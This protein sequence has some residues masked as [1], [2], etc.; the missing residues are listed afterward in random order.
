MLRNKGCSSITPYLWKGIVIIT[1]L[2]IFVVLSYTYQEYPLIQPLPKSIIYHNNKSI[3]IDEKDYP[4]ESHLLRLFPD[5]MEPVL[6][7]VNSDYVMNP[8]LHTTYNATDRDNHP[9]T[10]W[11]DTD[12]NPSSEKKSRYACEKQPL[13]FPLLHHL[14]ASVFRVEDTGPAFRYLPTI[15]KSFV[16][17]PFRADTQMDPDQTMC[18]RL[19]VRQPTYDVSNPFDSMYKPN[20]H[21]NGRFAS[22]WWDTFMVTLQ[23]LQTNATITLPMHPWSGYSLLRMD[24]M[25]TVMDGNSPE[26]YR[27]L[28]ETT[29][30]RDWVHVYETNIAL[31]DI[32]DYQLK[33]LLEYQA[34]RWNFEMGPVNAYLP[35]SL[36]VYPVGTDT[37]RVVDSSQPDKVMTERQLQTMALDDHLAL[38]LCSGA[39]HL[40]RWLPIPEG[41]NSTHP[42]AGI[43][44]HHKL[45]APYTCRYR[46]LTYEQFNRCLARRYPGGVDFF[47]DSNTRRSLKTMLSHGQ[48]C[49][50]QPKTSSPS[51]TNTSS[52]NLVGS[53]GW[54]SGGDD[55]QIRSCYCEDY[56]EATWKVEWFNPYERENRLH[57]EN[58]VEESAALGITEWDSATKKI[59]PLGTNSTTVPDSVPLYS[60]K[61]DGLTYL[62]IPGWESA[63]STLLREP[64]RQ[65]DIIV[66]SLGNWDAAFLTLVDFEKDLS[67]LIN[68]IKS[69]YLK[70]RRPK[71]IYRTPQYYCCR[72]DASNRQ[73][74]VSGGRI[75][76]FDDLTRG[77][78][79]NEL[80]AEVWN[81]LAMGEARAYEEKLESLGCPSNHVSSDIVELENQVLMNSLCNS[82]AA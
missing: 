12:N 72:V 43:D 66:F 77:R 30:E 62:N 20:Q 67:K 32:G 51:T 27:N 11:V 45:W 78:F 1:L 54:I 18:V 37:I 60:Y 68:W 47:G 3:S 38:P 59:R 79:V 39:N 53:R 64:T 34:G 50:T 7:R 5:I 81:T 26:W 10:S 15:D 22:P 23:H 25:G 69:T 75:E 21:Q 73:R 71:I 52:T 46:K 74:R 55:A 63:F 33:G 40:G 2:T 44:H 61:W 17:L 65:P 19:V 42:I 13:P 9:W 58:T 56:S 41:Y 80:N 29:A 31:K 49:N 28:E 16:L 6:I 14:A 70:D 57:F 76:S 82:P 48:W 36:S 4:L 24:R 8:D 35:Q